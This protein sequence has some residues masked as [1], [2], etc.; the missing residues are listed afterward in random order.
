MVQNKDILDSI[1]TEQNLLCIKCGEFMRLWVNQDTAFAC[2]SESNCPNKE[3]CSDK[4]RYNCFPCDQDICII[5]GSE[6]EETSV[7]SG[8]WRK[9]ENIIEKI[10]RFNENLIEHEVDRVTSLRSLC[11]QADAKYSNNANVLINK[12]FSV[13]CDIKE[14]NEVATNTEALFKENQLSGP[15]EV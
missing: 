1:S 8:D 12:N 7:R 13:Q 10:I 6:E 5:C 9:I 15:S 3:Y 11:Y 14:M 2:D 4:Q